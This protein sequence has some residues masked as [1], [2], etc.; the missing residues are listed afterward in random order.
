M[1]IGWVNYRWKTKGQVEL[2]LGSK[3]FFMAIFSSVEDCERIFEV[4]PY[5]FN[6]SGLDFSYWTICFRLEKKNFTKSLVWIR[7]YSLP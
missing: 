4:R 6:S 1:I 7:M 3:G 5:L 2:K